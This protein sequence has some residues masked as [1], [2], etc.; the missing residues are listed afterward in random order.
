MEALIGSV[1][2]CGPANYPKCSDASADML[3]SF[4]VGQYS[5]G[6]KRSTEMR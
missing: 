1:L 5:K 6:T 4:P 3:G 2:G